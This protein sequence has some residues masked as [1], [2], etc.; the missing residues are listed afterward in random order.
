MKPGC[1]ANRG[2]GSLLCFVAPVHQAATVGK[3][4]ISGKMIQPLEII[5]VD[6]H[7]GL[8]LNRVDVRAEADQQIHL[9]AVAVPVKM[10]IG[11]AAAMQAVMPP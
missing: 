1:R 6:G 3:R 2:V 9:V 4:E 7:P 10:K 5:S 8:D 11:P